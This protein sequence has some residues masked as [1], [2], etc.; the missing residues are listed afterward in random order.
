MK[1]FSIEYCILFSLICSCQAYQT[2]PIQYSRIQLQPSVNSSDTIARIINNYRRVLVDSLQKSIAFSNHPWLNKA[3]DYALA[4]LLADGIWHSVHNQDSMIAG[5][6]M[7]V[8]IIQGYWPR[9]SISLLQ[10]FQVL[11]EN[12]IWGTIAMQG[13]NFT[14]LI[15]KLMEQ[16]GWTV[17]QNIQIGK[18]NNQELAITFS[19]KQIHKDDLYHI[20]LIFEDAYN[21]GKLK[22]FPADFNWGRADV[23]SMLFDYCKSFTLN[24]KPL[25]LLQEK[26]MYA[27]DF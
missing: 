1:K 18:Q 24:G 5:V 22:D 20:V 6:L 3:P 10:L 25:P 4:N 27:R 23:R 9:G 12:K 13:N 19:G 16:G 17:S 21:S 2:I 7:P 8:S 15:K 26:R 11:P 14:D